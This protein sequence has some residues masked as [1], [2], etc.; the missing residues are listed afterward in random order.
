MQY[1]AEL[2]QQQQQQQQQAL[3][4]DVGSMYMLCCRFGVATGVTTTPIYFNF[5]STFLRTQVRCSFV[6]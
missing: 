1:I 3:Q 6:W 5:F 4:N 2:Q